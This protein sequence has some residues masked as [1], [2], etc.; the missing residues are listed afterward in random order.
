MWLLLLQKWSLRTGNH[1][2]SNTVLHENVYIRKINL[3]KT[4]EITE[5]SRREILNNTKEL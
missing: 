2:N 3:Q 1:I 5:I 4:I